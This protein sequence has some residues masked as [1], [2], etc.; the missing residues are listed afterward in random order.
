MV[1][2]LVTSVLC[3]PDAA[4]WGMEVAYTLSMG[5]DTALTFFGTVASLQS[6]V[7]L[8][9]SSAL[10]PHPAVQYAAVKLFSALVRAR[11][12]YPPTLAA[13]A[14]QFAGN[15]AEAGG[16]RVLLAAI[17]Q[18]RSFR[19]L[20]PLAF[21]VLARIHRRTLTSADLGKFAAADAL[22][23]TRTGKSVAP[24]VT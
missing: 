4:I 9:T 16:A 18:H 11:S 23:S 15:L 10:A 17:E 1:L 19:D 6:C 8:S 7:S 12:R 24:L 21:Q 2:A 3:D 22:L 20:L 5:S 14:R 13:C